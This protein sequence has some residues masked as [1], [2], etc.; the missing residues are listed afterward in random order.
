MSIIVYAKKRGRV[1]V[2]KKGRGRITDIAY[3]DV[4][5]EPPLPLQIGHRIHIYTLSNYPDKDQ[6]QFDDLKK[7]RAERAT[8]EGIVIG[9]RTA[10][11]EVVEL[12]VKNTIPAT[13]TEYVYLTIPY[14]EGTTVTL[15]LWRWAAATLAGFLTQGKR[16]MQLDRKAIVYH[17]APLALGV[18]G[19]DAW[20]EIALAE[21]RDREV[22]GMYNRNGGDEEDED[23]ADER[24]SGDERLEDGR[25]GEDDE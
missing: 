4:V 16:H 3:L 9:V 2:N 17:N 5:I 13:T 7:Y 18:D 6:P 11:P 8:M 1:P 25:S 10:E 21:M 14:V 24:D 22:G 15:G 12:V 20:R 23:E 19:T